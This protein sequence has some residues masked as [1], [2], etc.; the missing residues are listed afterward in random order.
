MIY[1]RIY[2]VLELKNGQKK[3]YPMIIKNKIKWRNSLIKEFDIFSP[4]QWRLF[5]A[6]DVRLRGQPLP[7][8]INGTKIVYA[9]N[10]WGMSK[11]MQEYFNMKSGPGGTGS[12]VYLFPGYHSDGT[13][14]DALEYGSLRKGFDS[15]EWNIS[16]NN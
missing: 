12:K 15:V 3:L 11:E 9:V 8:Y 2:K 7:D 6:N 1:L 14:R 4:K 10:V 13:R 5:L 16:K